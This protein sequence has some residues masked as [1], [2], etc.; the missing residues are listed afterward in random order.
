MTIKYTAPEIKDCG[1]NVQNESCDNRK[2]S[3]TIQSKS[4]VKDDTRYC[5]K[6]SVLKL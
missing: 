1:H 4:Y 3:E 5:C 2:Y 6:V